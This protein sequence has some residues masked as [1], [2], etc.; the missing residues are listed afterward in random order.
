[1]KKLIL[2]LVF[3]L[4]AGIG[5]H[6]YAADG[7]WDGISDET[8]IDRDG[9]GL[10]DDFETAVLGTNP[11]LWDTDGDGVSDFY[12]CAK[13]D[14]TKAVGSDCDVVEV[15]NIPVPQ[16]S[17]D[18]PD[19]DDDQDG[20]LNSADNCPVVFNPGQQDGDSDGV[21]DACDNTFSISHDIAFAR[22][23]AGGCSLG[24]VASSGEAFAMTSLIL[25]APVAFAA[26][27]KRN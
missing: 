3:V 16:P 13:L 17:L 6:A 15:V 21:G 18:E 22:G 11:D 19:G 2:L 7:D 26:F 4:V 20:I 9:D 24:A 27:R 14:K 5:V 23:G 1:M 8:D 12:D 25:F 10:F